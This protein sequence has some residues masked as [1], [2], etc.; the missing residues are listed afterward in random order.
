MVTS[1]ES[2]LK[3]IGKE[4]TAIC[5]CDPDSV[6]VYVE[7]ENGLVSASIFY[8]RTGSEKAHFKFGGSKV[9]E[10][11]YSLWD[12]WDLYSSEPVWRSFMY[13]EENGNFSVDFVFPDKFNDKLDK[14][15][16]RLAAVASVIQGRIVDYTT[17]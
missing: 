1:I 6:A 11:A 13:K 17:P 9:S 16:R 4:A 10:M 7:A 8:T 2:K 5:G 12:S 15:K 14:N 3:E